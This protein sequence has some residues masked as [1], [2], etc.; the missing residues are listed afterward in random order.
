MA[1]RQRPLSQ[2]HDHPGCSLPLPGGG[3]EDGH[4]AEGVQGGEDSGAV[5]GQIQTGAPQVRRRARQP[6][7][8]HRLYH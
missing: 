5:P 7:A 2:T 1:E 8:L 4:P 6:Q 3:G